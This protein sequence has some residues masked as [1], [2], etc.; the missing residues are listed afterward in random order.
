MFLGLCPESQFESEFSWTGQLI[1]NFYAFRGFSKSF[2]FWNEKNEE[3]KIEL[4]GNPDVF[5]ICNETVSG[6]YPF[7][8]RNWFLF[9]ETCK[10][11]KIVEQLK[12]S[13]SACLRTEFT[14]DDGTW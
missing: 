7:G 4:Y 8:V 2:M 10:N 13:F 11:T 12:L 5:A 3:W 1:G 6:E 14:C 9:N